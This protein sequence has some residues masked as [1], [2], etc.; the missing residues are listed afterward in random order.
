M[1]KSGERINGFVIHEPVRARKR[2]TP[3]LFLDPASSA[4]GE[5]YWTGKHDPQGRTNNKDDDKSQRGDMGRIDEKKLEHQVVRYYD[6]EPVVDDATIKSLLG[7][8]GEETFFR[9]LRGFTSPDLF[10]AARRHL[11]K[12]TPKAMAYYQLI[13]HELAR[14]MYLS[15]VSK[16]LAG[17]AAQGKESKP[18]NRD[19]K[20][21]NDMHGVD[22]ETSTEDKEELKATIKKEMK[23]AKKVVLHGLAEKEGK[24]KKDF[25][26]KKLREGAKVEMEHTDD[27]ESAEIIAMDH[28]T[29]DPAYYKKLK[30]VEKAIGTKPSEKKEKPTKKAPPNPKAKIG[31]SKNGNK[32]YNYGKKS[33]PT[34]TPG[35]APG[36][37][38][39]QHPTVEV[40]PEKLANMLH[41]SI[42]RLKKLAQGK[43]EKDFIDYFKVKGATFVRKHKIPDTYF[44]EV[45]AA[46]TKGV[47]KSKTFKI[48][49]GVF[50]KKSE[51]QTIANQLVRSGVNTLEKLA[52]FLAKGYGLKDS[53]AKK[54]AR[55]FHSALKEEGALS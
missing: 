9:S 53:E 10:D 40:Q 19:K 30:H 23:K 22:D 20:V 41:V 36:A 8:G 31:A 13:K 43:S 11:K 27:E 46:L 35:A 29:E 49:P 48:N 39:E 37:P 12:A 1:K 16:T 50:K 54:N 7:E 3:R 15:D 38:A 6:S 5:G 34:K 25:P 4:Q 18:A 28:L 33:T 44:E 51:L 52:T 45:H 24:T 2:E 17:M 21:F 26:K 55:E 32:T 14:R 42:D 47:A